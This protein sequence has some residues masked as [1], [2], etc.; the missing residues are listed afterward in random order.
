MLVHKW[1]FERLHE[2]VPI[3]LV[4]GPRVCSGTESNSKFRQ[5]HIFVFTHPITCETACGHLIPFKPTGGTLNRRIGRLVL[6]VFVKIQFLEIRL[7][8]KRLKMKMNIDAGGHILLWSVYSEDG[9]RDSLNNH[10][11]APNV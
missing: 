6:P 11:L 2:F 5:R 9:I 1:S 8:V 10:V 4:A 7:S 3:D